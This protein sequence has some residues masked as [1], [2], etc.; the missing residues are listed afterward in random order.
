MEVDILTHFDRVP[1]MLRLLLIGCLTVFLWQSAMAFD[2]VDPVQTQNGIEYAITGVGETKHDPHWKDFPLKLVMSKQ[3]E[4]RR[5]VPYYGIS[6]KIYTPDKKKLLD[7]KDVGPWL[8][9]KLPPGDYYIYSEDKRG[10]N[11]N[12]TIRIPNKK[13]QMVYHLEWPH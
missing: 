8:L 4:G 9:V 13:N 11:R 1:T 5:L 12:M 10:I 3:K 7:L 2:L 6:V